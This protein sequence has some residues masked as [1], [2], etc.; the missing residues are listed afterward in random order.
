M[1][2]DSYSAVMV[3]LAK[4]G[5]VSQMQ[6]ENMLIVSLQNDPVRPDRGNSFWLSRKERT[7][8]LSTWL[9]A[10]YK[11][12]ADQDL[13]AICSGCMTGPS[14]MYRIPPELVERFRLQELTE[15]EY[16][17]LFPRD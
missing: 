14:A 6:N 8:Y 4:L 5:L 12:P 17:Q 3:A 9:P 15:K 7:W 2:P 10:G 16:D 1:Q 11:I 13:L